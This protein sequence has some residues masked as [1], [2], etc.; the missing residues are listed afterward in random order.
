M[1]EPAWRVVGDPRAAI[2]LGAV[3]LIWALR[4]GGWRAV[5]IAGLAV[6]LTDPLCSFALKP[7]FART[8]PCHELAEI[9]TLGD[10]GSGRAFPS[11]HAANS[12]ALAAALASPAL[13][14]VA[15]GVGASRVALGQHW[16]SDVVGGWAVGAAVGGGVRW[17]AR[18]MLGWT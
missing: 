18:R 4:S 6:A 16:P 5:V 15:L 1:A 14:G 9:R 11:N 8:R 17:L 12:A 2:L 13:G 3:A 10:C 7:A